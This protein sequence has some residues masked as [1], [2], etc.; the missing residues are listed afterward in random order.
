ML[1]TAT[2]YFFIAANGQAFV[3]QL[4]NLQWVGLAQAFAS[5]L[6]N[7]GWFGLS[8]SFVAGA[9][10]FLY[11]AILWRILNPRLDFSGVWNFSEKQLELQTDTQTYIHKYDATGSMRIDQSV[12]NIFIV[13]GQTRKR[14]KDGASGEVELSSW[15]SL[16]CE[17]SECGTLLYSALDHRSAPTR[18]GGAVKYGVEIFSIE[19][20]GRFGRPK[21]LSSTVYHC[22]GAGTPHIVTVHYERT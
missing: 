3:D 2:V 21:K 14:P 12:R 13:E 6:K 15:W 20:R 5:I 22:V 19:A 16:A 18:E 9:F 10:I 7:F 1:A 8:W 4:K 17:L 11:E